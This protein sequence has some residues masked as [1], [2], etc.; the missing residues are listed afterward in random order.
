MN[1]LLNYFN[2][3]AQAGIQTVYP[4]PISLGWQLALYG[5]LVLGILVNGMLA[6]VRAKRRYRFQWPRFLVSAVIGLVVF[7]AVFEGAQANLG[8]PTLV[9][10]AG[11]F[12]SGLGYESLFS[13]IVGIAGIQDKKK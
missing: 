7:P 9:Q 8:Q 5:A 11:V 1:W 2:L 10:L 3:S 6:A 12:A 13:G 4:Q